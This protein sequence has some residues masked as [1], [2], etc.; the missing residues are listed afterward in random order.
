GIS[1]NII[2]RNIIWIWIVSVGG[3]SRI[4]TT[5]SSSWLTVV[6]SGVVVVVMGVVCGVVCRVVTVIS[7]VVVAVGIIAIVRIC[8]VIGLLLFCLHNTVVI[9]VVVVVVV[10]IVVVVIGV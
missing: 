3:R 1:I 7:G 2:G 5:G 4:E 8:S 6:A 9:S 10:G